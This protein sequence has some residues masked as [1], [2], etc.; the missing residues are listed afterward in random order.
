MPRF[1]AN[2]SMLYNEVDFLDRFA[3]AAADGFEG[4]EYLFPYPFPKEELAAQLQQHGLVQVL[5]NL[6]AG[7]WGKGERGLACLPDRVEEFRAGVSQAIEYATAL[8][9]RQLNC[10][11]G[12]AP[13]GV[14]DSDV[15]RTVIENLRYAALR[16]ADAGIRLLV[17]PVN[18]RDVPGFYLSRTAE[19]VQI[20]DE[21]GSDNIF[22]QYD[23]YHAQVMEGD[24][25]NTF[26]KYKT[27]IAHVQIA[28]NPGRN[29]PGTGEINYGFIF[30]T[31]NAEGYE[32]WVGCEYKPK[33]GTSQGLTWR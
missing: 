30:Q 22:L 20:I 13:K 21:A 32:G 11:V 17:E 12:L 15:R 19:T 27:R 6:P 1:C 33:A 26:K 24:L 31:L 25:V 2:L 23:F 18:T 14:S 16:L 10:L 7:N 5:H 28:D 8:G 9:C 29:E 3:A 4:V